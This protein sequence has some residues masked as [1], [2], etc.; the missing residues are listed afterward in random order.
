MI[1]ENDEEIH[2]QPGPQYAF[3]TSP[4]DVAIYGGAAGGGKSF[5]LLLEPAR[6]ISTIEGFGAVIFRRTTPEITAIGGLWDE[7]EKIYPTIG[8]AARGGALDWTFPPFSNVIKFAHMEQERDRFRWQGS[9]IPLIEFDELTHF[10]AKQFFYM[11]SRSRSTCGVRPYIRA[12]TN[13]DA[14]S[15]VADLIGWWID[16][17]TGS[18]IPDRSGVLR[19]FVRV[20]DT[21]I[22]GSS[23]EELL[24][25]YPDLP[26]LSLTFIPARLED[27]RIL[28]D[29]DPEYRARLLA[30]PYV[31]RARLLEGNWK[32]RPTA[33]TVFRREWFEI[34]DAAPPSV[35]RVWH[36]DMAATRPSSSNRDPDWTVGL[37][38]SEAG[39][40]YCVEDVFRA[41][42]NPGEMNAE[43]LALAHRE[44]YLTRIR[45][46]QEGGSAGKTVIHSNAETIFQGFDYRGVPSTGSKLIRAQP[47]AAAAYNRLISIVRAPWND[48]FLSEL[49]G[50]PDGAH[51]DQVD[52][53]AGAFTDAVNHAG[54]EAIDDPI[55][56]S[57]G[58][59]W[60]TDGN[61]PHF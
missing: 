29:Q 36:W 33:G 46:E 5:A 52:A 1:N 4:A 27:N 44:G 8:G 54:T 49:E 47:V 58:S 37:L 17:D 19:W 6:H 45:E 39:G 38:L 14:D 53:L 60:S 31:D 32:V 26:P 61:I 11:L 15:W 28:V 42:R 43:R 22:W 3:L 13:P 34:V 9:Q 2:A 56:D 12:T 40:R 24:E 30:L 16:Q 20:D 35:N 25:Q 59:P 10:T 7:A 55:F 57:S 18:P 21:L 51:D 41:R 48:L 23:K 50:F